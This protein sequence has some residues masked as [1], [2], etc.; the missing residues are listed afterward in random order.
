MNAHAG[1]ACTITVESSALISDYA[2]VPIA[3]DVERVLDVVESAEAPGE[4]TLEERQIAVPYRKDYDA[5]PGNGPL[6]WESQF[7]VSRWQLFAARVGDRLVGGAVVIHQVPGIEMLEG[8][9]D[10]AVLWDLRVAQEL[11]GQGIGAALLHAACQW[12]IEHGANVLKVETQ[13]INVSACRFYAAQGFRLGAVNR[14]AYPAF[15]AEIQL[16]WYKDL[17]HQ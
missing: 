3:F 8:R 17:I 2:R 9:D 6:G 4:W 1:A 7:D 11:R 15:P 5:I 13:Q 16:L 12:S 14:N 10:L